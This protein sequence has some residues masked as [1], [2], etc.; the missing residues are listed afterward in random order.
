MPTPIGFD[1]LIERI[2]I[3]PTCWLWTGCTGGPGYG[4]V[5]IGGKKIYTHRLAYFLSRGEMPEEI[6][7][8]CKRKLCMN[9]DHLESVTHRE[10]LL[11]STSISTI[12]R[13]KR[14][15]PHGHKYDIQKKCGSRACRQCKNDSWM[16]MY[17]RKKETR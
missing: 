16:R 10:N 12:N 2:E 15:C 17:W 9:P 14:A 4:Q 5:A 8:L 1:R 13:A 3:T 7:H 6:D 11:R